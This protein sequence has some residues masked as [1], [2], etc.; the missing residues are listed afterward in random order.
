[1]TTETTEKKKFFDGACK[2]G[3]GLSDYSVCYRGKP[4]YGPDGLY[5]EQCW[6]N[7]NTSRFGEE[8]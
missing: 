4:A 8:A 5:C 6:R 2:G 7:A 1:M 3:C